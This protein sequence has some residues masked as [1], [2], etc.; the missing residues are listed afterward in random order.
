MYTCNYKHTFLTHSKDN[1]LKLEEVRPY[2]PPPWKLLNDKPP[3]FI[4]MRRFNPLANATSSMGTP[5]SVKRRLA[6]DAKKKQ[7]ALDRDEELREKCMKR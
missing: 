1:P 3:K 6:N 2:V 5:R 7:S 4:K